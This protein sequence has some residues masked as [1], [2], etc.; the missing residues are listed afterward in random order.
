[1]D[2]RPWPLPLEHGKLL[3]KSEHLQ[4]SI[5]SAAEEYAEYRDDRD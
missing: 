3:T 1:M 5:G 4:G 2:R